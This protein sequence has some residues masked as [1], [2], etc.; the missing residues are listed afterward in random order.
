MRRSKS[1]L[2]H[3][4]AINAVATCRNSNHNVARGRD[5]DHST[6]KMEFPLV[7]ILVPAYNHV[8]FIEE[9]LDR[10]LAEP[11]PNKELVIID[12][13][14]SDGTDD[15]IAAWVEKH[16]G[17]LDIDYSRR[18]N[19]GI[20]AT[21]NELASRAK[22]EFLKLNSSD[23]YLLSGG[24]RAQIEYLLAHPYK[25]AV[26]SD[27][28]VID[29]NGEVLHSSGLVG[30]H[31]VNKSNYVTDEGV[32][33]EVISRWAFGGPV[34]M[35]R[36]QGL[37]VI[38]GWDERLRFEDWDF[39]LRLAAIDTVGFIDV[40]VC[41]YRLH[42]NNTCRTDDTEMRVANLEDAAATAYRHFALFKGSSRSRLEAQ[43]FLIVAKI[44]YLRR[45]P[46]SVIVSMVRFLCLRVITG[47]REL[48]P[49]AE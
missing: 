19:R 37:S 17:F 38:G 5:S 49:S 35:L 28:V 4:L 34:F 21:L 26:L 31:G 40:K 15:K 6:R 43:R 48:G 7:S 25:L 47:F 18:E 46:F 8:H 11:Y 24:V 32:R 9:C 36:K 41:A 1:T 39:F 20:S 14:S 2:G 30:L 23:D 42:S 29:E 33:R 10:V 12:D 16:S 44:A 3:Y 27:Y 13:G 22:G 45:K